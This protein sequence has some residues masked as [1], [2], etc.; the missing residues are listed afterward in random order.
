MGYKME[1][2]NQILA[3]TLISVPYIKYKV[4][5]FRAIETFSLMKKYCLFPQSLPTIKLFDSKHIL[6][7]FLYFS[8]TW[9]FFL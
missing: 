3:L 6:L 4:Y 8:L 7:L 2:S 5:L 1:K 9:D